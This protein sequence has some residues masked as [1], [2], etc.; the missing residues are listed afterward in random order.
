MDL[1]A[2]AAAAAASNMRIYSHHI[3]TVFFPVKLQTSY[4][5]WEKG[6]VGGRGRGG[7][8]GGG[9]VSLAFI[10]EDRAVLL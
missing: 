6:E 8:G 2:T 9:G 5:V 7:G 3:S 1:V 10:S 4:I